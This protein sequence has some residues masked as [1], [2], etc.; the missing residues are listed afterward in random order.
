MFRVCAADNLIT[1]NV[2]RLKSDRLI[3]CVCA[4]RPSPAIGMSIRRVQTGLSGCL[5][6]LESH[7]SCCAKVKDCQAWRTC[8]PEIGTS[9]I[10]TA[11][12][13]QPLIQDNQQPPTTYTERLESVCR[14]VNIEHRSG[15][16]FEI[17]HCARCLRVVG[18]GEWMSS[19]ASVSTCLEHISRGQ[20]GSECQIH[21]RWP[22]SN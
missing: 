18:V 14:I 15:K 12:S 22:I 6:T 16:C 4:L 1:G 3:H 19:C 17:S 9:S 8:G 5:T 20:I 13:N 7:S 21:T 2:V 10:S 11:R